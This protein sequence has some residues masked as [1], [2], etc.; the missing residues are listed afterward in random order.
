MTAAVS[1][2]DVNY[3]P[4][5]RER[6]A[7]LGELLAA[8][9]RTLD[10]RG[11]MSLMRGA[12]EESLRRVIPVRSIQLRE[13]ASRWIRP[14]EG[15]AGAESVAFDVP[16]ADPSPPGI[17]EATFDRGCGLGEWDLQILGVAAHVAALVL[18]IER[19][20]N[21]RALAGVPAMSK[22]RRDGAAPLIGSTAAMQALRSKIE[23]VAGTDFT[24]LLEGP[25]GAS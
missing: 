9:T 6:R 7:A 8:L 22:P 21:R 15:N 19:G 25:S 23:R 5:R 16:G 12:F 1:G 2:P 20:R 4:R 10:S 17:L 11:D 14:P 3:G 13:S 24:V 18:E